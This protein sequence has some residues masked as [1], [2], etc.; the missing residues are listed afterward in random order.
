MLPG[1][2]PAA[3]RCSCRSLT[4]PFSFFF[5]CGHA[6]VQAMLRYDAVSQEVQL[7][8][9]R[10]YQPGEPVVAWCGPQSNSK[11]LLNYGEGMGQLWEWE[12][13]IGVL[14]ERE[15]GRPEGWSWRPHALRQH[16]A[17]REGARKNGGRGGGSRL[18]QRGVQ[19][20]SFLPS[21]PPSLLSPA[22]RPGSCS[23]GGSHCVQNK[24]I[25]AVQPRHAGCCLPATGIVD[26]SNPFDKLPLSVTIPS[27]DPLYR[28]KRDRL[29]ELGLS[30]Q[31]VFQ[32]SRR[33]PLPPQLLPYL[34][35]TNSLTRE[36]VWVVD[37]GAGSGPVAAGNEREVLSQLI[38]H[39]R[40]RLAAYR[41]SIA[42]DEATIADPHSGPR[43]TA[44]AR[45]VRIEKQILQ[46][47]LAAAMVLPGAREA[48][49][50]P[51]SNSPIDL[52]P[53][54]AVLCG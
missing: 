24:R 3:R 34:R 5:L 53:A 30:T 50:T 6:A 41:T 10:P 32:L 13:G 48:A 11:L 45:L 43:Q 1:S 38:G 19:F 42:E 21:V 44:A 29:A 40:L 20:A 7:A 51:T 27:N 22:L 52:G 37:F 49:T 2:V 4:P 35:L 9:D 46:Q 14:H 17:R 16:P 33:Q 47:V 23:S 25:S 8:V 28:L 15:E 31:Q 39:L 12:A 54:S 18:L 26:E 36:E